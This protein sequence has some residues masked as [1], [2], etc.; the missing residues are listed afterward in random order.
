MLFFEFV[1]CTLRQ[2]TCMEMA[3]A[4]AWIGMQNLANI[5]GTKLQLYGGSPFKQLNIRS[6]DVHA[7]RTGIRFLIQK[8]S[9][10]VK[11][12]LIIEN[13]SLILRPPPEVVHD[14]Y[15]LPRHYLVAKNALH[16]VATYREYLASKILQ[17]VP[18][19]IF[20]IETDVYIKNFIKC[21]DCPDICN[22]LIDFWHL[23]VRYSASL[24]CMT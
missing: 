23:V 1:V 15:A 16:L 24:P 9:A 7:E 5:L 3:C 8:L 12:E 19:Y 4:W 22:R 14:L 18:E 17:D 2:S 6:S 10:E 21:I 11:S 13:K 20:D